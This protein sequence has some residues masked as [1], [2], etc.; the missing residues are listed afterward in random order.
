M[1]RKAH[2]VALA[3]NPPPR[4]GRAAAGRLLLLAGGI[5]ALALSP[6]GSAAAGPM[7]PPGHA[8]H[9]RVEDLPAPRESKSRVNPPRIVDRA[10]R[11]PAAPEGFAVNL[12]A[13]GL[14]HPRGL[15]IAPT[16]DVFVT[17][18]DRGR[19]TV[20]R[21]ADADGVSEARFDFARGFRRPNGLA[22]HEGFLYVADQQAVWR[23]P[24]VPGDTR[25]TGREPVTAPGALGK[26]GANWTSELALGPDGRYLYV[27]V[28]SRRNVAEE[29]APR[30][31][32]Q[33]FALDGTG[34][35]T[36]ASGLRNP[37]GLAFYPGTDTLYTIVAERDGLGDTLVP[38]FLARVDYGDFYGWPYAYLGTNPDP[39]FGRLAPEAVARSKVPQVLF[40][41]HSMPASVLFYS[42]ENFPPEF[43]GDAFVSLWG[44]WNRAEPTGYKLV[45]VPFEGREATGRYE[46]FLSGFWVAGEKKAEIWGRPAGL[47]QLAD[48]SLIVADDTAKVIWRVSATP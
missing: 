21:D 14:A 30:A 3:E 11:K 20:L 10:G 24:Y 7:E 44:S 48:G 41:A 27:G 12:F 18:P 17:E 29:A 2:I 36:F 43:R 46:T 22:F 9:I 4:H 35:I 39:E 13:D 28:G 25:G 32:V 34:Q 8:T 6:G 23:F 38:D 45:R 1:R 40:E 37:V 47:A 15:A 33:R 42:G 16:G 26:P 31:T 5:L 19:V